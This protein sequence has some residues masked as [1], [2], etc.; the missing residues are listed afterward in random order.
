[1]WTEIT[2]NASIDKLMSDYSGFHDSCI[3]S[4]S[5]ASGSFVDANGAMV[6]GCAD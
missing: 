1:M 5:Y 2:D 4:I 3:V 6:D